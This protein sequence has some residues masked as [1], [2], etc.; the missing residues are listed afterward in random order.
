MIKTDCVKDVMDDNFEV[1]W[2][3]PGISWEVADLTE[4]K[5]EWSV[6]DH[7]LSQFDLR[8]LSPVFSK[9]QMPIV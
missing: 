1:T 7:S 8:Q 5:L 6:G 3:T 2:R 4:E 9:F